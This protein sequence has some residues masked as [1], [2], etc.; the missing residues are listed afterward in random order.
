MTS[1]ITLR[2]TW[3]FLAFFHA[4]NA[5]LSDFKVLWYIK[6][7]IRAPVLCNLLNLLQNINKMLGK[8][9]V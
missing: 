8:P 7:N 4:R 6:S 9:R 2:K 3:Q 5:I 1:I